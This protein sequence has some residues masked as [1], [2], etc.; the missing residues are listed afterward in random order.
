M[1]FKTVEQY[2]EEKYGGKFVLQND[3]DFAD[4]IFLYQ[5]TKD[6][7][8]ADVHYIKSDEYSGYVHCNGGGCPACAKGIRVQSKLFI[9]V[10]NIQA[11]EIQF[12]DRTTRFEPKLHGDVFKNYPNPSD[13]VFRITR[14]GAANDRNTTYQIIAVGNNN[15]KSYADILT[16]F[17]AKFPDYYENVCRDVDASTLSVWVN[18][19][20]SNST[21][22][23]MPDYVATPRIT[24]DYSSAELPD[25]IL[26]DE[27]IDGDVDFN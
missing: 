15:V 12:W 20:N 27:E 17:N 5:S 26:S 1:A 11:G 25:P 3:G 10:Y 21:G 16:E 14:H 2:H 22:S 19:A 24:P 13:F 9:P 23:S 6:V 4:V 7:L 18:N 8:I